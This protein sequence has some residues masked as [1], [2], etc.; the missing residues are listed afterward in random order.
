[1]KSWTDIQYLTYVGDIIY[2]PYASLPYW[3]NKPRGL[4]RYQ[5]IPKYINIIKIFIWLYRPNHVIR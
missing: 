4:L 2:R 3:D 1:M 5:M